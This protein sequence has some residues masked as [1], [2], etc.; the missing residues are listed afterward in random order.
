VHATRATPPAEVADDV[1]AA[2]GLLGERLL[3][4]STL[5]GGEHARTS[6]VTDG[7][8]EYV[9][10]RFPAGDAA[11]GH[12]TGILSRIQHLAPL[13]PRL[14][15]ADI[16]SETDG[17]LIVTTRLP[18]GHPGREVPPTALA[19]QMAA[20]LVRIHE[21]DGEGLRRAPTS[22]PTGPGPFAAAAR[23][24][25]NALTDEEL[26]LTH[27]D[28][29]CGNTLWLGDRLT[30]VVDWSGARQ[31]PRGQDLAWCRLDLVLMGHVP[32]AETLLTAYE[33]HSG[34]RVENMAEWDLQAAAQ[35]ENDVED[36]APNY[37]G[38]GLTDLTAVRLRERLSAWGA[39]QLAAL[40]AD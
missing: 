3:Y 26:V 30:G 27:Y 22:A 10:R 39:M 6:V 28:Y 13:V 21:T 16:G 35:A 25:F 5:S 23:A 40:K 36:W 9:V 32:A 24:R 38:I 12:E 20:V 4:V 2:S 37:A 1:N 17:P 8:E 29:W 18:G 14:V 11:V 15:A 7:N 33:Q 19:Q 34:C 31:A